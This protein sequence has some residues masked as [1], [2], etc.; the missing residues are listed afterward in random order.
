MPRKVSAVCNSKI[1]TVRALAARE[2]DRIFVTAVKLQNFVLVAALE[3][4]LCVIRDPQ[5]V[6]DDF[7]RERHA[8]VLHLLGKA[9]A[10][11]EPAIVDD[12]SQERFFHRP[13]FV[14]MAFLDHVQVCINERAVA[15]NRVV[16]AF[17]KELFH[18]VEFAWQPDVILVGKVNQVARG[19]THGVFKVVCNA[20]IFVVENFDAWIVVAFND[21]Q[22]VVF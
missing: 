4:L 13:F 22:S 2:R 5:I 15:K 9:H 6:C 1:E 7:R 8:S 19:F 18:L 12:V 10:S 20:V 3:M 21:F 16:A 14:V 11:A 17:R